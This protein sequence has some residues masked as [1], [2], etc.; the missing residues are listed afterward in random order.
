MNIFPTVKQK[1][2]PSMFGLGGGLSGFAVSSGKPPLYE[3]TSG[4]QVFDT[5][6]AY[7]NLGPSDTQLNTAYSS[8]FWY[9]YSYRSD[10]GILFIRIPQTKTFNFDMRGACG[11]RGDGSA[12]AVDVSAF[13][14]LPTFLYK[15]FLGWSCF[16][17]S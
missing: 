16:L 10:K 13:R 5:A 9:N 12:A 2:L 3:W 4:T 11:G 8:R 14:S 1:P 6:G 7:G 15:V 17:F